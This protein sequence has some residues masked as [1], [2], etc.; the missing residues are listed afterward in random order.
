MQCE[1][2]LK[3]AESNVFDLTEVNM[4]QERD[5]ILSTSRILHLEK[6]LKTLQGKPQSISVKQSPSG[7]MSRKSQFRLWLRAFD[8]YDLHSRKFSKLH[9]SQV[10]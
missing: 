2:K 8:N 9:L 1:Q 5:L 7:L 10:I 4:Q 3:T 6:E